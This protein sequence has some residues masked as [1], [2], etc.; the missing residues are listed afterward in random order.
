MSDIL[1][2]DEVDALLSD[3]STGDFSQSDEET[4]ASPVSTDESDSEKAVKLYD[5]RR[6]DRVSK[7]QM[8]TLQNLH[9]S[10]ARLF[11]TTLTSYLRTLVEIE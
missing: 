6:P 1:S 10:Y 11:S 7:D 4:K 8:R 9:E 2:Q 5:F 3:I